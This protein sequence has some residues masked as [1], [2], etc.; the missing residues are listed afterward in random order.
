MWPKL[1]RKQETIRVFPSKISSWLL[2]L[3]IFWFR[4]IPSNTKTLIK[5]LNRSQKL[6]NWKAGVTL[7]MKIREV[8]LGRT[9]SIRTS[10]SWMIRLL[11]CYQETSLFKTSPW[12]WDSLWWASTGKESNR[13]SSTSWS[14][15]LV[16]RSP[17]TWLWSS[18]QVAAKTPFWRSLVV[19]MKMENWF[20]IGRKIINI[21]SEVFDITY[22]SPK[23]DEE[24][25]IWFWQSM[26]MSSLRFSDMFK[27][28]RHN[29]GKSKERSL[30]SLITLGVLMRSRIILSIKFWRLVMEERIQMLLRKENNNF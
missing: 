4:K 12:S 9:I 23:V 16:G 15:L 2:W 22:L 20:F 7:R 28:F 10:F 8:G 14:A 3:L 30:M 21:G 24:F 19:M 18:V 5:K 26:T 27:G 17:R 29:R 6:S 11:S 13:S 25:K 1:L